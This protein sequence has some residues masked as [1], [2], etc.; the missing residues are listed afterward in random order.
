MMKQ[1]KTRLPLWFEDDDGVGRCMHV[2]SLAIFY[3]SVSLMVFFSIG[4]SM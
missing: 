1:K 3:I 2:F 4:V